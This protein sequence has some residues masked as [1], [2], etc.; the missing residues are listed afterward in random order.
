MRRLA[1]ALLSALLAASGLPALGTTA[2]GCFRTAVGAPA[3]GAAAAAD[4]ADRADRRQG[5]APGAGIAPHRHGPGCRMACCVVRPTAAAGACRCGTS[6]PRLQAGFAAGMPSILPAAVRLPV[7][8]SAALD[9]R[10][11]EPAAALPFLGAPEHPP[12]T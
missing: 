9:W 11:P 10:R 2:G 1:A 8:P 6:Q 12:R 5:A 7:P 4:R 3:A